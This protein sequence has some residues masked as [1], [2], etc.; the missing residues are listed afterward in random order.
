MNNN[1][2]WDGSTVT[3]R[4]ELDTLDS[5]TVVARFKRGIRKL[6]LMFLTPAMVE[7]IRSRLLP[8]DM[9]YDASYFERDIDPPARESAPTIA[10][11]ILDD[12]APRLVI[13]V[14]CGTGALLSALREGGCDGIGLEYAQAGIDYCRQRTL[15]VRKFDI[16]RDQL[17]EARDFD[18]VISME[19]AE[20][21]P[22]STADK[23][24]DLLTSLADT[25]I[26]TAAQPNQGG[27]DHVN[28][29]PHEY[30]VEKFVNR[31]YLLDEPLSN[32]W[33]VKWKRSGKVQSWYYDNLMVF[34][35]KE[36]TG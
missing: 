10:A 34:R 18:A 17:E 22:A 1:P 27:T 13:D 31:N 32:E 3:A 11:T 19:V 26:F 23:Y 30:W 35:K 36:S 2:G 6:L 14:G 16:E 29:Q 7:K 24:V 9:I 33:Q 4:G 8:H 20:H 12:L 5:K 28:E 21:L 15:N 25:V